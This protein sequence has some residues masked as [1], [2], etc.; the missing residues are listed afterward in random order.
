MEFLLFSG[1]E[2]VCVYAREYLYFCLFIRD[3]LLMIRTAL[4]PLPF[5]VTHIHDL[6]QSAVCV[7]FSFIQYYYFICNAASLLPIV[8]LVCC[9]S[10]T[11]GGIERDEKKCKR[12]CMHGGKTEAEV[13]QSVSES[14]RMT[15]FFHIT[16]K[17][18]I[19]GVP[20]IIMWYYSGGAQ[21]GAYALKTISCNYIRIEFIIK[22]S[23]V[24]W[25]RHGS[26]SEWMSEWVCSAYRDFCVSRPL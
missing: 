22:K 15:Y 14:D 19:F 20:K 17:W 23:T 24:Y 6:L 2:C 5:A 18:I 25:M 4:K 9:K 3:I 16:Y 1:C 10:W 11:N 21:P 8:G 26:C 13:D 7:Y 12:I